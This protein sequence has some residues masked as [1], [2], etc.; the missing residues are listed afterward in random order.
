MDL[1]LT[2]NVISLGYYYYAGAMTTTKWGGSCEEPVQ[3]LILHDAS[4]ILCERLYADL[5][6]Q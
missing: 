5:Q 6:E 3:N 2:L 4:M 1:M